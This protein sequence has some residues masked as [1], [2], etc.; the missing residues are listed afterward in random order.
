MVRFG[1]VYEDSELGLRAALDRRHL[2]GIE[3]VVDP[4]SPMLHQLRAG[5]DQRE[6]SGLLVEPSTVEL[7]RCASCSSTTS[8]SHALAFLISS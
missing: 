7:S 4:I 1:S 6:W 5:A 3:P 2:L 8:P